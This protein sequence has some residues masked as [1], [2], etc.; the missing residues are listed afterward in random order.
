MSECLDFQHLKL[1]MLQSRK[2][3]KLKSKLVKSDFQSCILS[4]IS[5]LGNISM[6]LQHLLTLPEQPSPQRRVKVGERRL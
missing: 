3:I 1:E 6:H 5:E 2:Q 4:V